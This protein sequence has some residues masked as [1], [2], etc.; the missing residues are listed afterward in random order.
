MI[1]PRMTLA[2][3]YVELQNVFI[4]YHVV[5]LHHQAVVLSGRAKQ[6]REFELF[7]EI[8]VDVAGG[9]QHRR[10]TLQDIRSR[11][12]GFAPGYFGVDPHQLQQ[13]EEN[14]AGEAVQAVARRG[15]DGHPA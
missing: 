1:R 10:P 7:G 15:R 2:T 11:E 14:R 9:V 12:V 5:P 3:L 4:L 13:V 8:L 6:P